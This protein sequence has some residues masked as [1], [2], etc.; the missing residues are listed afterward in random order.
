MKRFY[1]ETSKLSLRSSSGLLVDGF[2]TV[3]SA[4][5][6]NLVTFTDAMKASLTSNLEG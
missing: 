2:E 6:T 1:S 3:I 5:G 4:F